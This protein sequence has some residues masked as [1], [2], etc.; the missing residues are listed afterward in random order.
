MAV[1]EKP[2]LAGE[3]HFPSDA[4]LLFQ[5]EA[6]PVQRSFAFS[7]NVQLLYKEKAK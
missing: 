4:C 6:S 3:C 2:C 1:P 5:A 7:I